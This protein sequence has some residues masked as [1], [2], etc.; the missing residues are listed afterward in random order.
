MREI[1]I[2]VT[3]DLG[4][5]VIPEADVVL[6]TWAWQ[7]Q[8]L[9]FEA[10]AEHAG[11]VGDTYTINQLLEASRPLDPKRPSLNGSQPKL[12]SGHVLPDVQFPPGG[13]AATNPDGTV[14]RRYPTSDYV[15]YF[16]ERGGTFKCP[17]CGAKDWPTH[18]ALR[19][20]VARAHNRKLWELLAEAMVAGA[21]R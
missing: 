20:H 6:I 5:E 16:G 13:Y 2:Q 10:C 14:T 8:S 3:C 15:E 1:L 9:E 21:K 11:E 4:G 18:H 12:P 17:L 7:R 19:S